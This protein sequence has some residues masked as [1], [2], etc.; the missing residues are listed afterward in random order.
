MKQIVLLMMGFLFLPFSFSS[1]QINTNS[2]KNLQKTQTEKQAK[3]TK[4]NQDPRSINKQNETKMEIATF[5]GGCFWCME[6]VF[7]KVKGVKNVISGFAGGKKKHPSY[8]E[9][10]SG[11]TD[12][13]EVVQITFYP[14][15]VSYETLLDIYWKNINPTDSKGQ[16]VDRGPQY[17]PVIFYHD[18]KQK[19]LAEKSKEELSKKEIFKKPITTEITQYFTFFKAEEYHQ[20]YHKKNPIRY[21]F[22]S[23]RSGRN[24]FLRKTWEL[25]QEKDKSLPKEQKDDDDNG[26]NGMDLEP[27]TK[28][29]FS[30]ER[31][32]NKIEKNRMKEHS[33]KKYTKPS[34]EE[35]KQRLSR[36]QYKVTQKNGTEPPFKNEYWDNKK[37]GIYV[38]IV[39][40]EPL[41]S[42]LDKYDSK[43]GWPS[44]TRPLIKANITTHADHSFFA[45]RTEVRSRHA[46]SHLGHVFN[47]GPP[48]TGLRYCINSSALRFIPAEELSSSGYS[49]FQHLFK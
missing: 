13:V 28:V 21:W 36:L 18:E 10:S 17:R 45:K 7:E 2:K 14:A 5:A 25:V 20:D 44:F 11:R 4:P 23:S 15:E 3:D 1:E 43:T 42:S 31:S 6:A 48:P 24:Q 39:S 32:E 41:F 9:V 12:H 38:D 49:K 29:E 35:I 27:E 40:G 47:D 33:L 37:P 22:Y 30:K 34:D 16:F 8:K 19:Q 26:D 46:D